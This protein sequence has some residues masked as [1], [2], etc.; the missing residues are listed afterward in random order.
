MNVKIFLIVLIFLCVPI[1]GWEIPYI[2]CGDH[3]THVLA[4][5]C[6]NNPYSGMPGVQGLK[7]TIKDLAME[8]CDQS[9]TMNYLKQ[10]CV[11]NS[12]LSIQKLNL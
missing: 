8:C 11:T 7:S 5:V 12:S 9:C 3:F 6:G 2:F 1:I 4:T 10:Y